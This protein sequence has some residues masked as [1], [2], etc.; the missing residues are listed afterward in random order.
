VLA[1][2]LSALILTVPS[3]APGGEASCASPA[4]IIAVVYGA[5]DP[6]C[7]RNGDGSVTAADLVGLVVFPFGTPTPSVTPSPTF[8]PSPTPSPSPMATLSACPEAGAALEFEL[9]D[10]HGTMPVGARFTGTRVEATCATALPTT[11]DLVL[12]CV[13]GTDQPCARLNALAPGRWVVGVEIPASGQRQYERRLLVAGPEPNRARY[14][15]FASV[16]TVTSTANAGDGTLRK[17]LSDAEAA[18]KPALIQFE[19]R[20]F[21]SGRATTIRLEFSL[22]VLA[23]SDVTIDGFDSEGLAGNRVVDAGGQPIGV[24]AITGAR[25]HVRGVHLRN[26]GAADRDVVSITGPLADGNVIEHCLI[27]GAAT[28]DAIGVDGGAG[29]DFDDT[30]NALRDCEVRGAADKG[31]KVT[32]D[33]HL[34]VERSWV[35]GNANGGIQATIGGRVEVV[36]SLVEDNR[37]GSAQ[38]GLAANANDGGAASGASEL[39]TR[40]NLVRRNG[41]NGISVRAFSVADLRDDYTAANQTSGLRVFNDVGP[42]AQARVEGVA[43]ACNGTDGAV[44]ANASTA[45]FG[46]GALGSAGDNAFTQNDL[47]GGGANL[48]NATGLAVSAVNNQWENCGRGATCDHVQIATVDLS[49]RGANTTIAP[50]QA[51]RALQP[52]ITGVSPGA[53]AA[54]DLL[55]IYGR[56]FNV[57]D[58]HFAEDQCADVAGRNRCVPLRGNCVRIGGVPAAVEAVTPTMLAVRWPF[59]CVAPVDVTVTIDQGATAATSNPFPVCTSAQ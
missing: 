55:R 24:L 40:G 36:E 12:E 51:H 43:A 3:D 23:A 39:R 31:V 44:V 29:K 10:P 46:G 5:G 4:Q 21:P 52:A 1:A 17:H 18:A 54:G 28:G 38:N 13:P 45:D 58:G 30:V 47:P 32:T 22:P 2:V 27:D 42:P 19:P 14:T 34:R 48:R 9:L 15:V 33:A 57:I 6:A 25:N 37:G 53:G 11:Y 16:F 41:A 59:T 20:V 56:G 49:D 7:D 8:T 26:A 35:H 50:A